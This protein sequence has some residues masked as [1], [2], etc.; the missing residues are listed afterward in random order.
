M[1]EGRELIQT[2]WPNKVCLRSWCE[3]RILNGSVQP[4]EDLRE[5]ILGKETSKYKGPQ[6]TYG[7]G[8][9]EWSHAADQCNQSTVRK[10]G[11]SWR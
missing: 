5:D 3:S 9:S 2:E 1:A 11:S 10:E 8:M 7:Q 6:D 4:R